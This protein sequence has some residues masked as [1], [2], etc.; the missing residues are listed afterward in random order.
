MNEP[1]LLLVEGP[2]ERRGALIR[3]EGGARM[4]GALAQPLGGAVEALESTLMGAA[5]LTGTPVRV[6]AS[7]ADAQRAAVRLA[8]WLGGPIR[9]A[10]VAADGGRL[11]L[12]AS[13]EA[14]VSLDV[15]AA[16]VVPTDPIERRRRC[17]GVLALLGRTDRSTVA[18]VLGDL[19]DAPLRDRDDA[20]DQVRAAAVADA[21]RRLGEIVAE[22]ELGDLDLEGAPLLLV[23]GA[24]SSIATGALPISVAAPLVPFGR[25]RVLLEPYG[26]FAA[27]GAELVDDEWVASALSSLAGDLLL[28]GGD[29][30][31]VAGHDED[32]LLVQTSRE[33]ATL[34]V[35]SLYPLALRSGE[36]EQAILTRGAQTIEVTLHGG[37]ARASIVFGDA[38]V[39][40][41]EIRAGNLSTAV[42]A[43]TSAAPIPAPIELLPAGSAGRNLF[44]GRQLLGD[45][46]EGEV[47]FSESEPEGGG[48]ERAVAAGVLA[49]GS[50][51]P[52]TLL[53]ARAVGVRGVIVHGLSDGERD[54]LRASLERR[55]A[56]AVATAA[57][58][59]VIM[60][61]RRPTSGSDERVSKL[62]R[63][64]HGRRVRFSGDPVGIVVDG[65]DGE[66]EPGDVLVM[67]GDHEGRVG[68]WEG[69]A[70]P[71][72]DD[73]LGAVRIDGVL[74]AVPLGELQRRSA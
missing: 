16:A 58:G 45:L 41:H 39:A 27:L 2:I 72:A 44:E 69:L 18:D 23:G 9:V 34:S 38:R 21:M 74:H 63:G 10:E 46:V 59:L 43:A 37:I 25:T 24:A 71:R 31:R 15:P 57:F 60:T 56:A 48:W 61:P 14:C 67:G 6:M 11:T 36:Q 1:L 49:V 64:L 12:V 51:S 62:L 29:L 53:R 5:G 33:E 52:E 35:P 40:S 20:R 42:A 22:E 4:L 28:P 8:S 68:V 54:A 55:I 32:E 30:V 3:R 13:D 17:D 70:D 26:V 65:A 66:G 50:A 47:V 73:P 19:A 7:A